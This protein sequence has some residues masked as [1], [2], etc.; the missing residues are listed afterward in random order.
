MNYNNYIISLTTIPSRVN[1]IEN[2][3][4][5]LFEQ[6][7]K[8]TK[9]I[10]NIPKKYNF[11]FDSSID[12][13]IIREISKKYNN[14][15][16][17]NYIDK[18]YGPGT[19][20]LGLIKSNLIEQYT[21]NTNNTNNT[22]IV[23]VDDDI[24]YKPYMIEYFDKYNKTCFDNK[25]DVASFAAY[26]HKNITIGQGVDGFFI[27]VNKLNDFDNYYNIIK[28]CDYVNY[29][30]DYY[31]S[32]Y[33]YIKQI[34]INFIKPPFNSDIYINTNISQVDGLLYIK[35]KYSRK[36]L[37]NKL[38]EILTSLNNENKFKNIKSIIVNNY[39]IDTN[40]CQVIT[41]TLRDNII[42]NLRKENLINNFQ[43]KYNFD[44]NFIEGIKYKSWGKLEQFQATLIMLEE[45]EKSNYDYGIICQDDFFPI[46]NFLEELN[47]TIE[48][49]PSNWNCLHLCPGFLWG[50]KFRD[51]S[52][53]GLLNYEYILEKNIFN[54]HDSGRFFINCNPEQYYNNNL[55]L[56]GPV[57]FIIK[58]TYISEFIKKYKDNFDNDDRS[59][60]KILDENI[61]ICRNPQLGYEEEC[62]GTSLKH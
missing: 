57:A 1:Y 46:D 6:T 44:I 4:K 60:V 8:P 62:G 5:S 30:D 25:L 13:N 27:N 35:D 18:D 28:D 16:F 47:K 21:N 54:F 23:L 36:N 26:N 12:E 49:L 51:K 19:K 61:F 10:L 33:F 3:I 34:P 31:I 48:L 39:I 17:I 32:Y 7:L 50:R 29:H 9:I 11:R 43:K 52:K 15:L 55:W 20:L 53:I 24:F 14:L 22:Y 42:S 41:T 38:N 59:L 2:T 58:K 37:N 40:N 45:Y 56:G